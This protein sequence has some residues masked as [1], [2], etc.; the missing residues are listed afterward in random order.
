MKKLMIIAFVVALLGS[1]F[2]VDAT[3]EAISLFSQNTTIS[4]M[5]S[6]D[7]LPASAQRWIVDEAPAP[8]TKVTYSYW[9]QAADVSAQLQ[10]DGQLTVANLNE[11]APFIGDERRL[12]WQQPSAVGTY[13]HKLV[14]R[15]ES[16]AQWHMVYGEKAL[17]N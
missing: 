7:V 10:N 1:H 4:M 3:T 12:S 5:Q 2:K 15:Y 13:E 16:G 14:I 11:V 9:R 6:G 8:Q 17:I